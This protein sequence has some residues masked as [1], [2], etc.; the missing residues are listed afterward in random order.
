MVPGLALALVARL[1][2]G[3]SLRAVVGLPAFV[4]FLDLSA[5]LPLEFWSSLLLSAG[6]AYQAARLAGRRRGAFDAA[7]ATLAGRLGALGYDTAGFVA[8]LDYCGREKGLARGF[9]HY[10]DYPLTPWEVFTRYVG[11]GRR[12]DQFSVALLADKLV[13]RR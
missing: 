5:K 9:A 10:E 1:R 2:G 6:L 12:V 3:V 8:N 13:G 11:L 4:G 7:H